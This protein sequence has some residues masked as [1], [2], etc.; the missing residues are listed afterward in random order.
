MPEMRMS[1]GAE[2]PVRTGIELVESCAIAGARNVMLWPAG[3]PPL[4]RLR[5]D[6]SP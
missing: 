3:R 2:E 1:V 4:V 5:H 6:S